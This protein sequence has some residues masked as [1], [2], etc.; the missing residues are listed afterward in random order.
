MMR[1]LEEDVP[2]S[3]LTRDNLSEASSGQS[4]S[5]RFL[6]ELNMSVELHTFLF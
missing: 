2:G 5:N 4:P 1:M 6:F 3:L